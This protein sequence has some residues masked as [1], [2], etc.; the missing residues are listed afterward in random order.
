[1][2]NISIKMIALRK[3]SIKLLKHTH[4]T[5]TEIKNTFDGFNRLETAE[6]KNSELKDWSI[7]LPKLKFKEEKKMTDTNTNILRTEG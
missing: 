3:K 5:A 6:E 1:M 4:N 2:D 7:E